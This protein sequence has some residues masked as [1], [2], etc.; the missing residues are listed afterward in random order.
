[1]KSLRIQKKKIGFFSHLF[2]CNC[3]RVNTNFY[4]SRTAVSIFDVSIL[5]DYGQ[6][7]VNHLTKCFLSFFL[8]FVENLACHWPNG[9]TIH[10]TRSKM[11]ADVTNLCYELI[12]DQS[13]LLP[14]LLWSRVLFNIN[15]GGIPSLALS[16]RFCPIIDD[17]LQGE[18]LLHMF[19]TI[20]GTANVFKCSTQTDV[21]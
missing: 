2:S 5:F 15:H 14:I 3:C 11:A 16:E 18:V 9:L 8:F 21:N 6:V 17:V 7:V 19:L 10:E 13:C 12:H 4:E 20:R 1:M